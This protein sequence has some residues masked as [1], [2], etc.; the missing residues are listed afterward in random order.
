MVTLM[1][2]IL[3][4]SS[5][6]SRLTVS[7]VIS[8]PKCS[9]SSSSLAAEDGL[10][11]CGGSDLSLIGGGL[12]SCMPPVVTNAS[13]SPLSLS[14]SLI[15]N[16]GPMYSDSG[17]LWPPALFAGPLTGGVRLMLLLLDDN[18]AKKYEVGEIVVVSVRACI[19]F[20]RHNLITILTTVYFIFQMYGLNY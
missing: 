4:F 10:P 12:T 13:Y 9:A 19:N 2:D 6:S 5:R 17:P 1:D 18:P 7:G 3:S 11:C 8:T 20:E 14:S 16:T 15:M